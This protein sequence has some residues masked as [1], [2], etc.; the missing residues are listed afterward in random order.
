MRDKKQRKSSKALIPQPEPKAKSPVLKKSSTWGDP[1]TGFFAAPSPKLGR[2][3]GRGPFHVSP[4]S[5]KRSAY[6]YCQPEP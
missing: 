5:Q 3:L 2:G 1:K 6:P 4:K